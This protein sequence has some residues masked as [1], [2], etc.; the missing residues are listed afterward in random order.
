[1]YT[2]A[3]NTITI[4]TSSEMSQS[5]R[6]AAQNTNTDAPVAVQ[7]KKA[8]VIRIGLAGVKTGAVGDGITA[9]D[10]AAAVQNTLISYLKVPNVEVVTLEAKLASAISAEAQAKEC[11]YVIYSNVSHKK[12]GGG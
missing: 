2:A 1:M 9:A 10:L 3:A 4:P 5:L 8:G 12:G 6:I 11:D 7:A